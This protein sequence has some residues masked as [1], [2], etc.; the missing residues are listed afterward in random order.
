MM[1]YQTLI[2]PICDLALAA[3]QTIMSFYGGN[4]L[5][6]EI[7]EDK[8]P[9]TAADKAANEQIVAALKIITP[10]IPCVA[11]ENESQPDIRG[12]ERYWLVDPL[13]GT[14]SF[15][16]RTGE[17]T[18]NIGLID[19]GKP[20]LGAI[21]IPAQHRLFYGSFTGG[22]YKH[23][24]NDYPRK[25]KAR[26]QPEEG[27]DVVVSMSHL[28]PETE[29]YLHSLVVASRVS[30]ASSLKFCTVAEGKADIYPRFGRTM[31]WDTAAGHAILLAAGGNVETLDGQE[32]TYGK[33]GF[34]N[35]N[36]VAFGKREVVEEAS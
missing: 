33:P 30:A 15:I 22:A 28:T 26:I 11:E 6:T 35:P 1:T 29:A 17:F 10:D 14:K 27:A 36:F 13:D 12:A 9:V 25:I 5:A 4:Q 24:P 20:V 8:S 19:N 16:R 7:K 18:V 32:L 21:Y 2:D 23:D 31:E 34:E 3:G